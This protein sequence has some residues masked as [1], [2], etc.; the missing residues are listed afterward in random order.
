MLSKHHAL[1]EIKEWIRA[2][3]PSAEWSDSDNCIITDPVDISMYRM[4]WANTL[5]THN[6]STESIL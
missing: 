1:Q 2:N 6:I 3:L 5:E 4:R